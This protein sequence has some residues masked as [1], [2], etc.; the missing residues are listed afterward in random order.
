MNFHHA[1]PAGLDIATL[2]GIDSAEAVLSGDRTKFD[3]HF[4]PTE[5][6]IRSEG[7]AFEFRLPAGI[8]A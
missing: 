1:A 6:S 5:I 3:R 7:K 8:Q 4:D 2:A